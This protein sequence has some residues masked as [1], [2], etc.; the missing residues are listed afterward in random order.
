MKLELLVVIVFVLVLYLMLCGDL[1]I[2]CCEGGV[3]LVVFLGWV[4]LELVLVIVG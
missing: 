3:L 1:I 2:S 4:V